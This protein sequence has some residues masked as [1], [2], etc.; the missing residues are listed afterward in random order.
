MVHTGKSL[1]VL[2]A[3]NFI[4]TEGVVEVRIIIA[5]IVC[6]NKNKTWFS[7]YFLIDYYSLEFKPSQ[8]RKTNPL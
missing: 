5:K 2:L 6:N 1:S 7:V 3:I 8:K 4:N